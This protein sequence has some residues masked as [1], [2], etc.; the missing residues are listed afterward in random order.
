MT[1]TKASV[2]RAVPPLACSRASDPLVSPSPSSENEQT[3]HLMRCSLRVP[4]T[5]NVK[6]RFAEVF[7]TA[8]TSRAS[9]FA[10]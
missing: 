6:R 1:R 7:A 8:V 9:R 3:L 4:R 5:P 10:A 2:V